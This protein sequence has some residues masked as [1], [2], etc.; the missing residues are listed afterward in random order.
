MKKVIRLTESDLEKIVKRILKE[1]SDNKVKLVQ[2][3]LIFNGFR[4]KDNGVFGPATKEAVRQ[5]QKK[6][7]IKQTGNVG[8]ITAKALGVQPLISATNQKS[9]TA[10]KNKPKVNTNSKVTPRFEN[11]FT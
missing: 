3:A 4:I 11:S 7:G 1:Q 9:A 8:P 2:Q 6:K 5:F 10:T